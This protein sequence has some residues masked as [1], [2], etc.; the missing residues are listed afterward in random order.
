MGMGGW[1]SFAVALWAWATSGLADP[2]RTVNLATITTFWLAA[3]AIAF[4]FPIPVHHLCT[5]SNFLSRL[6]PS[7]HHV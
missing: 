4:D 3:G 6:Q 7:H 5:L 2:T 1:P